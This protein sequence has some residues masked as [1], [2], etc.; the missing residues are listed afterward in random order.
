MRR[1]L[2]FIT[3]TLLS[4]LLLGRASGAADTPLVLKGR[5]TDENGLP[6]AGARVKIEL[7][8][9][10]IFSTVSDDAGFFA[11]ANLASGEYTARVEKEGFFVL[12]NQKLQLAPETTEFTFTLNHEEEVRE[13]V[14]VTV[15]ENRIDPTSTPSTASLSAAEIRDIPVPSSHDL[16]QSLVAMPEVV[17][18]NQDLIHVAGSRNTTALYLIDGVEVGDPANNGLSAHMIVEAVRSTEIQTARFGAEYPHPGAAVLSYETREGDDKWRFGATDFIPGINIQDGV[19]LGNFYP[20]VIFSGPIV[21]DRFWFSQSFDVVHTLAHENGLPAGQDF[22]RTWGGNSWSRLLWKISTNNSLHIS[23]LYNN[24]SITNFGLDA[25][26]PQSTTQDV[27]SNRLF[28]SVKEQSYVHKTL[29]EFGIGIERSYGDS[30]PQGDA[31]YLLLV[32]GAEGNYYQNTEMMGR[33]SQA[34]ADAISSPLHWF[35]AHTL[36]GGANLGWVE[37]ISYDQRGEIQALRDDMT[38]ARLTTFTGN[39]RFQLSNTQ[40]GGFLQDSWAMG[41]H[42]VAQFGVRADWDRLFQAALVQPRVAVNYL[43]FSDNRAKLSVGWGVYNIPLNLSVIGQTYDQQEV[44]TLY[45]ATGTLPVAGPATSQFVEPANGLTSLQQPYFDIASAGYQ[46]RFGTNTLLNLEFLARDE[47]HGLVYETVSPGQIGSE[48]LLQT[49]RRDKYRAVTVSVRH[50]FANTA[51]VFGSYTRSQASTDQVLDPVLGQLY[52]AAQQPGPLLWDAPNRLLTWAS[53]PTPIWGILFTDF[54]E[55]RSGY[56]FS[57]VNQQQFLV[58]AANSFRFPAYASLTIGLEKK[59]AFRER[60]F[61]VRVAVIN[62]LGRQNPD[63]VVNN[64][65]A[66]TPPVFGTFSGGQGRAVTARLRFVGLRARNQ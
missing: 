50:T 4:F 20:R 63:V 37:L 33:R 56:P 21:K 8:G 26:H 62:I 19:Q 25:L 46:Q 6:V 18:D 22:T 17:K 15:S 28:G 3:A 48:F 52:F 43:P 12:A 61:A 16:T 29:L 45:N 53:V 39:P 9:G 54:F 60:V 36:S 5:V 57:A 40:A 27:S 65:D 35:G 14:D 32:N 11:L 41:A 58:G 42:L 49:S 24:L 2:S 38:L 51:E 10:P 66:I 64:V 23:F 7:A 47:H 44:D 55:Y 59:F 34:F 13:K 31:P 1:V 30:N